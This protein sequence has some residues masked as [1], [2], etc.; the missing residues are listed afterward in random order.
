MSAGIVPESQP[1]GTRD[2]WMTQLVALPAATVGRSVGT[3]AGLDADIPDSSVAWPPYF[4]ARLR[5]DFY[6]LRQYRA[7]ISPP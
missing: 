1:T 6:Y 7:S 2:Y 4:P 5:F 3:S